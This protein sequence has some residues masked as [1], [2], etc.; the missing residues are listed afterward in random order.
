MTARSHANIVKAF[1]LAPPRQHDRPVV[2]HHTAGKDPDDD[3]FSVTAAPT[4]VP[5]SQHFEDNLPLPPPNI[6][7]S[8][9]H[10]DQENLVSTSLIADMTI[11]TTLNSIIP[12]RRSVVESPQSQYL[13]P[14]TPSPHCHR[15]RYVGR[16]TVESSQTQVLLLQAG[17]PR[18]DMSTHTPQDIVESSQS[19]ALLVDVNSPLWRTKIAKIPSGPSSAALGQVERS[20]SQ[21]ERELTLSMVISQQGPFALSNV[22]VITE[23]FPIN[24]EQ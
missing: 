8:I 7:N 22:V 13:F 3:P 2:D 24:H 10:N 6:P 15:A 1:L 23:V 9:S 21:A 17:S 11:T 18:R 12:P 19:Q 4:F 5:S 16:E 20:Q 14:L